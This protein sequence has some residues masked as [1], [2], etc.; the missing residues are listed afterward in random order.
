MKS[1][2]LAA[3]AITALSFGAANA[4]EG[5]PQNSNTAVSASSYAAQ[6]APV[7]QQAAVTSV[8]PSSGFGNG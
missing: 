6:A 3:A 2:I 4:G 8:Q 7:Q 1:M 5:G